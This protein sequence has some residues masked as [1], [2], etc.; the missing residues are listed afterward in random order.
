[1]L[2]LVGYDM[3]GR[4]GKDEQLTIAQQP[5]CL[6][7]NGREDESART[8]DKSPP[9]LAG[10]TR[11]H[12]IHDFAPST[13]FEAFFLP[14]LLLSRRSAG[15]ITF[16][17]SRN[18]PSHFSFSFEIMDTFAIIDTLMSSFDLTERTPM[19]LPPSNA[20]TSQVGLPVDEEKDGV[21][22]T[23]CTIA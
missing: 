21:G 14:L 2:I 23:Y 11:Y 9:R 16:N 13:S 8:K 1:M 18:Q 10:Q 15:Q 4:G 5:Y 19:P 20:S 17:I 22:Y 12:D 3:H 6:R 7:E